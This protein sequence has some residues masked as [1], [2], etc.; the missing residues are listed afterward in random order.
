MQIVYETTSF[1]LNF[2][3]FQVTEK[4]N[5]HYTVSASGII[6]THGET[7]ANTSL[8]KKDTTCVIQIKAAG[9]YIFDYVYKDSVQHTD[10]VIV[11]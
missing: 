3:G 5:Q 1:Q 8:W 9:Q 2:T 6:T 4:S 10:T 11:R 7:N